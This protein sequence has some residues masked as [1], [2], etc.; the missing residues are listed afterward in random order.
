MHVKLDRSAVLQTTKRRKAESFNK[1]IVASEYPGTLGQKN[2]PC[3]FAICCKT[4]FLVEGN[5][6]LD[7][8]F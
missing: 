2:M 7:Q 6:K 8:L 1:N 4:L 5:I 3:L